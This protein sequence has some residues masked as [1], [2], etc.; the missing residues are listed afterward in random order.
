MIWTQPS[1]PLC[2]WQCFNLQFEVSLIFVSFQKRIQYQVGLLETGF[3]PY[4][5]YKRYGPSETLLD[6]PGSSN[7][8]FFFPNSIWWKQQFNLVLQTL[9]SH[10]WIDQ[11]SPLCPHS[12]AG[13]QDKLVK[14]SKLEF[15]TS[16][17]WQ[18]YLWLGSQK[19]LSDQTA[20]YHSKKKNIKL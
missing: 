11:R 4:I 17:F 15:P 14:D 19:Q 2:L 1:G 12:S 16:Q 8:H 18:N 7:T 10:S 20:A 13:K 9:P 3:G 5:I 6:L